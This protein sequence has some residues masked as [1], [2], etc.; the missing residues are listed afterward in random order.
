VRQQ[1]QLR[2]QSLTPILMACA[3]LLLRASRVVQRHHGS[4]VWI[5]QG[6]RAAGF[7]LILPLASRSQVVQRVEVDPAWLLAVRARL[8]WPA[9]LLRASERASLRW[10]RG[11]VR[12]MERPEVPE[13]LAW[14]AAGL[15]AMAARTRATGNRRIHRD[16]RRDRGIALG[17]ESAGAGFGS[18][19]TRARAPPNQGQRPW[20]GPRSSAL[21]SLTNR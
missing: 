19:R 21:R 18:V 2:P 3:A 12:A 8:A 20:T 17:E 9:E 11:S 6:L 7:R 10:V 1:P 5:G 16:Y 14:P 4:V 13:R 15:S